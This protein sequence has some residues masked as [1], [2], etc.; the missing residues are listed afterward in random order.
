MTIPDA[1]L[2]L[3]VDVGELTLEEA[4]IFDG[5]EARS[6]T[7]TWLN[8][9]RKFLLTYSTSWTPQQINALKINELEEIA[10]QLGEALQ[11]AAVPLATSEA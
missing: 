3:S 5:E 7:M 9:L 6:N 11:R 2:E 1:P 4:A 10:S 8:K